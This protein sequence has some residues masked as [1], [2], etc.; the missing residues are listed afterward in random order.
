MQ[1][2][3]RVRDKQK[4]IFDTLMKYNEQKIKYSTVDCNLIAGEIIDVISG[5][6]Y[7]ELMQ[8]TYK[9]KDGYS[10]L[11]EKTGFND[12]KELLDNT[13]VVIQTEFAFNGDIALFPAKSGIYST[14]VIFNGKILALTKDRIL[15]FIAF[16]STNVLAVYRVQ[17]K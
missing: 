3:K 15:K 14:G 5:S 7:F 1:N 2:N 6:N 10:V 16:D 12:I 17:S 11:K 4:A 13:C 8:G 9:L